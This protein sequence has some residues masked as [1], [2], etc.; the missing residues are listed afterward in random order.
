MAQLFGFQITRSSEKGEQPSFVLPDS[1]DG[2]TTYNHS[3]TG[4][5]NQEQAVA[6]E[7]HSQLISAGARNLLKYK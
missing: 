2:A 7:V 3:A 5:I 4:Q 1:E 6:D